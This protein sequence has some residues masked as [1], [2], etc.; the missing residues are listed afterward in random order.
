MS[1]QMF[2]IKLEH[3]TGK[4]M[5][6]CMRK[7]IHRIQIS[8]SCH[9]QSMYQTTVKTQSTAEKRIALSV[10]LRYR[11][12]IERTYLNVVRE[13]IK[14]KKQK[15]DTRTLR[16][17]IG[18]MFARAFGAARFLPRPRGGS[19]TCS[20]SKYKRASLVLRNPMT[21]AHILCFSLSAENE[22]PQY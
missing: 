12:L 20:F 7:L 15:P 2:S 10:P 6:Q 4:R 17:F 8:V 19:V 9:W 14:Q 21:L 16:R 1:R 13:S 11:Q 3:C 18:A 5:W 22:F